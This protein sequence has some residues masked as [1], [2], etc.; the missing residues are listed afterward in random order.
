MTGGR[1][2]FALGL[3]VA[4]LLHSAGWAGEGG[5]TTGALPARAQAKLARARVRS[6]LVGGVEATRAGDGVQVPQRA[7][8]ESPAERLAGVGAAVVA[9]GAVGLTNGTVVVNGGIVRKIEIIAVS[10]DQTVVSR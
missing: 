4:T 9:P 3:V 1:A 2:A 6:L 10:G 5:A 8:G 7:S